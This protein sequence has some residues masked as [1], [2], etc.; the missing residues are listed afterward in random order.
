MLANFSISCNHYPTTNESNFNIIKNW[1]FNGLLLA[2]KDTNVDVNEIAIESLDE[3]WLSDSTKRIDLQFL[4]SL[5]K[6]KLLVGIEYDA[7]VQDKLEPVTI[8]SLIDKLISTNDLSLQNRGFFALSRQKLEPSAIKILIDKLNQSTENSLRENVAYVLGRQK[9]EPSAINTLIDKLNLNTG[10]ALLDNLAN[11]LGQQELETWAI[12]ALIQKINLNAGSYMQLNIINV[13]GRQKLEP[14]AINILIDKLNLYAGS[15]Q[16]N[17]IAN[18]LKQQKLESSA[19]NELIDK[20]NSVI[21]SKVESSIAAI[22]GEQELEPSVINEL[23]NKLNYTTNVDVETSIAVAL[24]KQKL[25]FSAINALVNKLNS[26]TDLD[27]VRIVAKALGKQELESSAINALVSKLYQFPYEEI[28][29]ADLTTLRP[30]RELA[31]A[32]GNQKLESTTINALI[33]KLNVNTEGILQYRVAEVL[34]QQELEPF[35]INELINK[36]NS[37]TNL[38][39]E[40]NVSRALGGQDLEPSAI[41]ALI[42]KLT[43][44]TDHA[45]AESVVLALK[46]QKLEPEIINKVINETNNIA[47]F[48]K[49]TQFDFLESQSPDVKWSNYMLAILLNERLNAFIQE[50]QDYEDQDRFKIF[51]QSGRTTKSD[52]PVRWLFGIPTESI[53]KKISADELESELFIL[54]EFWPSCQNFPIVKEE[55]AKQVTELA[56]YLE[57]SNSDH[58]LDLLKLNEKNFSDENF[59]SRANSLNKVINVI[60]NKKSWINKLISLIPWAISLHLLFWIALLFAY[61]NSPTVQS[62]FFWNPEVLKWGGLFYVKAALI[63]I[64]FLRKR[65]LYPFRNRLLEDARLESFREDAYFS[66]S[67]VRVEANGQHETLIERIAKEDR[68]I[69]LIGESGLGKTMYL[70]KLAQTYLNDTNRL[71]VYLRASECN[72]GVVEA[73]QEKVKGIAQDTD[74]LK[75]LIFI[76]A[77]DVFID[78]LNEV[79]PDTRSYIRKFLGDY[80]KG[81]CIVTSQ[82]IPDLPNDMKQFTLLPLNQQQLTNFLL[83]RNQLEERPISEASIHAYLSKMLNPILPMQELKD[84]ERI[85]SNPL[86]LS[87][88]GQLLASGITQPNLNQLQEKL[89]QQMAE[90]YHSEHTREEG[91]FPLKNF[92]ERTYEHRLN[93]D[94]NSLDATNYM[95]EI[96]C[97]AKFKMVYK[98][99]NKERIEWFFRHDKIQDFF[100]LQAFTNKSERQILHLGD[101]KFRGVY[102]LLALKLPFDDAQLLREQIIQYGADHNDNTVSNEFI[103]LLRSRAEKMK[104]TPT[105]L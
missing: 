102:F 90:A 84:N 66:E 31:I 54:T 33:D 19:I 63:H 78:G 67:I 53:M 57:N 50:G 62:M 22:L 73:I 46:N 80:G 2:L 95:D 32:L 40:K 20:F 83:K 85:L 49:I 92:S 52:T 81:K 12:N 36:L 72:N 30:D 70:R 26:T 101:P 71:A 103:K 44:K 1:Q 97:M 42:D 18:A 93:T 61:P 64:P 75:P 100:L 105:G 25:S 69:L 47:Q 11:I 38:N 41:N 77:M 48:N 5:Q 59:K 68:K 24:G 7:L 17:N 35:A 37:T 104:N 8:K 9:L 14:S 51:Y 65:I 15:A 10:T 76:G 89:Y 28:F 6:N 43:S 98:R 96:E 91:N 45:A 27:V 94:D 39:L 3:R 86:D 55:F 58:V 29:S 74:F 79:S 56:T 34:S 60:E 13:L 23:V 99:E 88:V 21:N 4:D 16:I 87:I 82:P